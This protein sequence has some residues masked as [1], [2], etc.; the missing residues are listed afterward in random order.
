MVG[1]VRSEAALEQVRGQIGSLE[2]MTPR[3]PV[4]S[5]AFSWLSISRAIIELSRLPIGPS[6]IRAGV[7]RIGIIGGSGH[8]GIASGYQGD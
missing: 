4:E 3:T 8:H 2:A 5:R 1:A 6:V 7:P